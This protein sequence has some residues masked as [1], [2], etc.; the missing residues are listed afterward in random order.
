MRDYDEVRVAGALLLAVEQ[1]CVNLS[2]FIDEPTSEYLRGV[3]PTGWYPLHTYTA[4]LDLVASRYADPAPILERIGS[5]MIRIWYQTGAAGLVQSA[6]EFLQFQTSS[7]GYYSMVQGPPHKI[8]TFELVE[9]DEQAGTAV[10][11]STT[12]FSK[13]LERGVILAGISV[14]QPLAYANVDNSADVHTYL[15]EF[16]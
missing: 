16:H 15:I 9:L 8:G 3:S 14:P 5:E 1:A 4:L 2:F 6:V 10:L 7:R 12:P 11:R 13:D